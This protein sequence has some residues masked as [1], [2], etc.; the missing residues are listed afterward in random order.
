[1]DEHE[2]NALVASRAAL[3]GPGEVRRALRATLAALR[4]ALADD[5]VRALEA[6]LPRALGRVLGRRP[7]CT[8]RDVGQ[9]YEVVGKREHVRRGFAM[10]HA[11]AVLGVLAGILDPEVIGRLRRHLPSDIAAL[12]RPLA[13]FPAAP[14]YVHLHPR[15]R[16]APL[17]TLS[18]ARPGASETLA[19]VDRPIAHA[20]SVARTTAG[21]ADRMVETARSTRPGAEDETLAGARPPA[22]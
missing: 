2:L 18:R 5:D 11:Q 8:V 1:M 10:E 12:L 19:G 16:A 6:Q 22:R 15:A 3:R 21:H 7:D 17:Q 4:S 20:G 13:R 14:P 9:L